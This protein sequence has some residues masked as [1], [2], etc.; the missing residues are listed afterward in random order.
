MHYECKDG[1]SSSS[2]DSEADMK[3]AS[4]VETDKLESNSDSSEEEMVETVS[5]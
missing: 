1:T 4:E 3:E 5:G 2:E